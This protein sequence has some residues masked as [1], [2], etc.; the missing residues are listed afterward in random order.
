M[1]D[2]QIF[3]NEEF[4]EIRTVVINNEPYFVGKDVAEVLGYSEPRSAVSK[5]VDDEDRGV[6]KME[7]PSGIQEMTV[8]NESGLYSLILS[9]IAISLAISSLMICSFLVCPEGAKISAAS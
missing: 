1:T 8:I 3:K 5:K 2:L 4:G 6:A 9:S 7:T